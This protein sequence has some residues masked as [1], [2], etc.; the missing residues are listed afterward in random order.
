ML[1]NTDINPT[2]LFIQELTKGMVFDELNEW[3][4]HPETGRI[5]TVEEIENLVI[6]I[7]LGTD[8]KKK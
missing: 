7:C 5:I 8:S 6:G 4:K 1:E 3:Y 2:S